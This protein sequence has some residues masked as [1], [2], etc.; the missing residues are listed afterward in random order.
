MLGALD[1]ESR[2][3]TIVGAGFAGLVTALALAR[4]GYQIVVYEREGEPGGML[5]T[6]R[7]GA[8]TV[9]HAANSLVVTPAMYR[10][11]T[12]VGVRLHTAAPGQST[13][14]IV[15]DRQARRFPPLSYLELL[16]AVTTFFRAYWAPDDV[17]ASL[18]SWVEKH[19]GAKVLEYVVAPAITGVFACSPSEL[20]MRAL[21]REYGVDGTRN[22]VGRGIT[23]GIQRAFSVRRSAGVPYGAVVDGG[24]KALVDAIYRK[25]L[26]YPNVKIQLGVECRELPKFGNIC[27]CVPAYKAA[28]LISTECSISAQMLSEVQYA[29]LISASFIVPRDSLRQVPSGTGILFPAR[30]QRG[31]LGILFSSCTYPQTGRGAID[32]VLLRAFLGGTQNAQIGQASEDDIRKTVARECDA[33]WGFN[34]T[35][36]SEWRIRYWPRAIPIYSHSLYE[37]WKALPWIR[38]KGRLLFASYTGRVSL[39]GMVESV[40]NI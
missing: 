11:C 37:T 31:V 16:G 12:D 14:Y 22:L 18:G 23:Q 33:L 17:N 30:E 2:K 9:E 6:E 25:L 32:R 19:F 28:E 13:K 4:Q 20:S 3:V 35:A 40:E 27:L 39:R 38:T 21:F 5:A 29:P 7:V 1:P 34:D 15:R 24:M 36:E 26:T 10:L 8:F